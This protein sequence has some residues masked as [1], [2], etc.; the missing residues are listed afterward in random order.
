MMVGCTVRGGPV[1]WS[2][3][4]RPTSALLDS[5]GLADCHV[6]ELDGFNEISRSRNLG[7]SRSSYRKRGWPRNTTVSQTRV[8]SATRPVSLESPTPPRSLVF[9]KKAVPIY[10][11][12]NCELHDNFL[13]RVSCLAEMTRNNP[14]AVQVRTRFCVVNSFPRNAPGRSEARMGPG[15][16]TVYRSRRTWHGETVKAQDKA[17]KGVEVGS[18][19]KV[20]RP[21]LLLCTRLQ[22]QR[23]HKT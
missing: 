16:V 4:W 1:N 7:C 19:G 14:Y 13:K 21:P 11:I 12:R 6:E 5:S 15:A 2:A 10:L 20:T 3:T 17:E 8:L 23:Q 18:K 9:T 22:A